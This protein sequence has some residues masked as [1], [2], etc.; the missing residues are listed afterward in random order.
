MRSMNGDLWSMWSAVRLCAVVCFSSFGWGMARHFRRAGPPPRALILSALLAAFSAAVNAAALLTSAPEFPCAAI[1][2]YGL[3]AA[4]FWSA[5]SVTRGKLSACWEGSLS[6]ALVRDGPYRC[7]RHPFYLAYDLTWIAGYVATGWWPLAV[8]ALAMA[9]VYEAAA[10]KEERT[11][12]AGPLAGQY[13][14]YK[15]AAGRY[16]PR[17]SCA[18]PFNTTRARS[19]RSGA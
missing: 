11:L 14:I 19:G 7:I 6:A 9:V 1:V 5:V 3:S 2:L 16:W 13:K 10:R 4:L 8:A 12:L 18:P 17:M 15:R